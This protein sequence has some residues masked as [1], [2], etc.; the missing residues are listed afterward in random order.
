MT[1]KE[2]GR[3]FWEGEPREKILI[4]ENFDIHTGFCALILHTLNG[5]RKA[6]EINA[7]PVFDFNGRNTCYLY[8]KTKGDAIWEYFF[9]SISPYTRADVEHWVKT[10]QLHENSVMR[11]TKQQFGYLHHHD[12]HRL[13]TFWAWET[14]QNKSPWMQQKRQLG[15]EFVQ[16]YVRPKPHIVAKVDQFCAAH[17]AHKVVFGLHIR[18][19][20]FNYATPIPLTTYLFELDE[21]I[22]K[23]GHQSYSIFVATD[24]QQYLQEMRKKYQDKIVAR[25]I[26]RSA[27]HIVPVKLTGI[28]GYVKGEE[29]LIDLLILSR[30]HHIIK[31]PAALGEISLW[32]AGHNNVTDL[33]LN[34]EFNKQRYS[35]Q[36]SAFARFNIN[37]MS[38]FNLLKHKMREALLRE[39]YSRKTIAYFYRRFAKVRQ[40][41]QH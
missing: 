16:N 19:T 11:L 36:T 7:I 30:C 28:S 26:T 32:F 31:G 21:L 29:A 10:G 3:L 2:H 35:K 40:W 24:Q 41:L 15:R 12:P 13:A 20:D 38:R 9:D 23:L 18:G 33:A 34:C 39:L 25:D 22:S 5:L 14:P 6:K 1:I 4:I 37:N 17:F 27:N 8:D